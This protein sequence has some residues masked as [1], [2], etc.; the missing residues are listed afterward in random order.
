MQKSETGLVILPP[1]ECCKLCMCRC[2]Q[3]VLFPSKHL[4]DSGSVIQLSDAF[5]SLIAMLLPWH[6]FGSLDSWLGMA[7]LGRTMSCASWRMAPHD[8][9]QLVYGWKDTTFGKQHSKIFK[10]LLSFLHVWLVHMWGGCNQHVSVC[11]A[12]VRSTCSK[13][14]VRTSLGWSAARRTRPVGRPGKDRHDS[15]LHP[16]VSVLQYTTLNSSETSTTPECVG[17]KAK[18]TFFLLKE[19]LC[20]DWF[21]NLFDSRQDPP[22]EVGTQPP[23]I[24][25]Q[26]WSFAIERTSGLI[27]CVVSFFIL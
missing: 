22:R 4:E 24:P 23:P 7:D 17:M 16:L 10:N 25:G 26:A 1:R 20:A 15:G 3:G 13:V 8:P 11:W 27:V 21:G 2:E 18:K 19:D 9:K 14:A 6:E 12:E 5:C